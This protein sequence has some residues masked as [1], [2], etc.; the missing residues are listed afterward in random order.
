MCWFTL[1]SL[2]IWS[3]T[4]FQ[5]CLQ[6]F[7]TTGFSW[8]IRLLRFI[9]QIL[10]A[11]RPRLS[12]LS[13]F[14]K[15]L[16]N[17]HTRQW[18]VFVRSFLKVIPTMLEK[19][20]SIMGVAMILAETS[21]SVASGCHADQKRIAVSAPLLTG[22]TRYLKLSKINH[23]ALTLSWRRPLSYRNQSGFYMIKFSVMK[24]WNLLKS[25]HCAY[26][27]VNWN[28]LWRRVFLIFVSVIDIINQIVRLFLLSPPSTQFYETIE[29][30]IAL[31]ISVSLCLNKVFAWV[32]SP[33][34]RISNNCKI[35]HL[36][37]RF[38][39]LN[40]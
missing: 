5:A 7:D 23:W 37:E 26:L 16:I 4:S 36:F 27:E 10:F 30:S 25:W 6:L 31:C 21:K 19:S 29:F 28:I 20:F 3:L 34:S 8:T 1:D 39:C 9:H 40:K 11:H 22:D 17:V 24:E 15:G 32:E 14:F 38:I 2:E 35:T 33:V 13:R 12:F 18:N